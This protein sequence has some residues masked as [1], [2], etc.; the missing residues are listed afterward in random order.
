MVELR[1]PTAEIQEMF[2][3]PVEKADLFCAKHGSFNGYTGAVESIC[4]ECLKQEIKEEQERL[5]TRIRMNAN[6]D[7]FNRSCIP[8]RYQR[9]GFGT[10]NPTC[11]KSKDVK[12][13]ITAFA[14]NFDKAMMNGTSFLLSGSTGTGK[15]HLGCSAALHV[16][17]NGHAAMY[18]SMIDM[19]SKIK[20]S[21]KPSSEESEESIIE[22]FVKFDLLIIDEIGHHKITNM[23]PGLAF[24]V[25]NRRYEQE[26]PTIG[27]S[28]LPEQKISEL[29]GEDMTS[30]LKSGGGGCLKFNWKDYRNEKNNV[31]G[32]K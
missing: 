13:I 9:K 18:M 20:E 21:W 19:L 7:V 32:G 3:N 31:M 30:R 1:K 15:T 28:K 11:K 25:V 4:P 23:D 2:D 5:H 16:I 10:Y 22:Q 17:S 14:L 8:K 12:T 29:F 26:L 27:I 24:K 6:S